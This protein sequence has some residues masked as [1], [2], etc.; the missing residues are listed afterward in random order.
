MCHLIVE[1]SSPVKEPLE[2]S[3]SPL[4]SVTTSLR[5]HA[6]QLLLALVVPATLIDILRCSMGGQ[7]LARDVPLRRAREH[8]WSCRRRSLAPA[9][10]LALGKD[11]VDSQKTA[12][13][14]TA[15]GDESSPRTGHEG[16]N[17]LTAPVSSDQRS[18]RQFFLLRDLPGRS[19]ALWAP[20]DKLVNTPGRLGVALVEAALT[21]KRSCGSGA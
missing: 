12:C 17:I 13:T 16:A 9:L 11:A 15:C 8:F 1:C 21:S 19:T 6:R 3:R 20:G 18:Y 4:V 7:R 14:A 2:D 5:Q 10:P